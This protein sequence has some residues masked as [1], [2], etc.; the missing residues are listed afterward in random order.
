MYQKGLSILLFRA[1]IFTCLLLSGCGF[2][3]LYKHNETENENLSAHFSAL[4][5]QA[6]DTRI[7]Q[8]LRNLLLE[9]IDVH[10]QNNEKRYILS[11]DIE[12]SETPLGLRNDHAPARHILRIKTSYMLKNTLTQKIIDHGFVVKQSQY[13]TDQSGFVNRLAREKAMSYNLHNVRNHIYR[14]LARIFYQT[15]H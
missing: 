11:F 14:R 1:F 15:Q 4:D 6:S 2:S 10:K 9:Q 13:P 7:H 5:I 8:Q 3:P 12:V